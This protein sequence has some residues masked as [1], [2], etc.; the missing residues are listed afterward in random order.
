MIIAILTIEMRG[1]VEELSLV[2]QALTDSL[3]NR[4]YVMDPEPKT[5]NDITS[6]ADVPLW[7]DRVVL[8]QLL[9]K[10]GGFSLATF[11]RLVPYQGVCLDSGSIMLTLRRVKPTTDFRTTTTERFRQLYPKAWDVVTIGPE[12]EPSTSEEQ[13]KLNGTFIYEDA[14]ASIYLQTACGIN[15]CQTNYSG[16]PQEKMGFVAEDEFDLAVDP[17]YLP[18]RHPVY[19]FWNYTEACTFSEDGNEIAEGPNLTSPATCA[20]GGGHGGHGGYVA[21]ITLGAAFTNTSF[22]DRLDNKWSLN[23]E[24]FVHLLDNSAEPFVYPEVGA[25]APGL[26]TTNLLGYDAFWQS[27]F[28]NQNAASLVLEWTMYNANYQM[29][30]YITVTF[31]ADQSGIMLERKG[32][33]R[34]QMWTIYVDTGYTVPRYLMFIYAFLT[35]VYLGLLLHET[36]R[37][38]TKKAWSPL[39]DKWF[40][41]NM[42]SIFSSLG[43]IIS[44]YA[45]EAPLRDFIHTDAFRISRLLKAKTEMFAAYSRTSSLATLTIC[46]RLVQCLSATKARAML[47]EQTLTR[48]MKNMVAYVGYVM[49]ILAGFWAFAFIHFSA[50]SIEFAETF[51]S[52]MACFAM[53]LGDNEPI[54]QIK[55]AALKYPFYILFMLFFFFISVQMFNAIINYSYN[56]VCE[57]MEPQIERERAEKKRKAQR[58][59]LRPNLFKQ[60][61]HRVIQLVKLDKDTAKQEG[62]SD[63]SA[64]QGVPPQEQVKLDQEKNMRPPDGAVSMLLFVAF[65]L[66]YFRFLYENLD[67]QSNSAVKA[68]IRG[69]VYDTTVNIPDT[70]EDVKFDSISNLFFAQAWLY[71]V[72]PVIFFPG[73]DTANA[74]TNLF[75]GEV[76][77]LASFNCIV[78]NMENNMKSILRI[79]KTEV[80]QRGNDGYFWDHGLDGYDFTGG[81]DADGQIVAR[82]LVP[83]RRDM[84]ALDDMSPSVPSSLTDFCQVALGAVQCSMSADRLTFE[85]QLMA[86]KDENF[87]GENVSNVKVDFAAYNANR[88]IIIYTQITLKLIASGSVLPRLGISSYGLFDLDKLTIGMVIQRL[89]P[90]V[91]YISL[92]LYFCLQLLHSFRSGKRSH[93]SL[94]T[95]VKEFFIGDAFNLMELLSIGI[96]FFSFFLFIVWLQHEIRFKDMIMEENGAFTRFLDYMSVLAKHQ[97]QYNQLSALNMLIIAVRPLKFFRRDARFAQLFKT[98]AD[99]REDIV[100][101]IVMLAITMFGFVLFAFV[102]FGPTV[103]QLGTIPG[104]LIYCFYYVLG[105]FNFWPLWAA[106]KVMAIVFF[107][108][109]LLLF[110]CVFT[111]IFFAIVDRFFNAAEPP[112]FNWKRQLKGIFGRCVTCINWDED[113]MMEDHAG[114]VKKKGPMSRRDRVK[115][116]FVDMQRIRQTAHEHVATDSVKSSLMLNE[117]CEVDERMTDVLQWSKEQA[118]MLV[119]DFQKLHSDKLETR[120]A[121]TFVK[122]CMDSIREERKN[123]WKDMRD[124]ERYKR[125]TILVKER[126]Q[127]RDQETLARYIGVL[128]NKIKDKMAEKKCLHTDV[129]HLKVETNAMRF[130]REHISK[131]GQLDAAADSNGDGHQGQAAAHGASNGEQ[132]APPALQ[133]GS[134][135]SDASSDSSGSAANGFTGQLNGQAY[136][137][138]QKRPADDQ[139]KNATKDMLKNFMVHSQA[140]RGRS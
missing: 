42:V 127:R 123:A 121:T 74:T 12:S 20:N 71:N 31:K 86:M 89:V 9:T 124:A 48:A 115:Q 75:S 120:N 111:N 59:S 95:G 18:E 70:I 16:I 99:A 3:V 41:I 30:T 17:A 22:D 7:L 128:Q 93:M 106:D 67:I 25:C 125:Y 65:A 110:Y 27:G 8:T 140:D 87:L 54:V 82:K 101:F 5:I 60:M 14:K 61:F 66:C 72:L 55:G 15:T 52:L 92:V 94:I 10:D 57:E 76:T 105:N 96:S 132:A 40:W 118:R 43:S 84:Q 138:G 19:T 37:Q 81:K 49:V 63:K 100:F 64:N 44:W 113:Y 39:W 139:R 56:L 4:P 133:D 83:S 24:P 53:F 98:F 134:E 6:L 51:T 79:T 126:M 45:Y 90:G 73:S 58:R 109:Y 62:S 117:V 69:V 2:N 23:E 131:T 135:D 114:S 91:L 1:Q 32:E 129:N 21:F 136:G 88:N 130:P 50:Y 68:A 77:C 137:N 33:N 108:V 47:L 116:I 119:R 29:L 103:P 26:R 36:K 34:V 97:R 104:A 112:P 85:D 28:V 35:T 80:G 107:P 46:I 38:N 11:N 13:S 122:E 78:A 102:S